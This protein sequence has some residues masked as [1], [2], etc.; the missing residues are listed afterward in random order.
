MLR[1]LDTV[2][3]SVSSKL[4]TDMT[5]HGLLA[6]DL[7]LDTSAKYSEWDAVVPTKESMMAA[8]PL[9]WDVELQ[10]C[11]PKTAKE[12]LCEQQIKLRR[13]WEIVHAAFPE[14]L[15]DDYTYAWLLINTRSFYYTTPRTAKLPRADRMVLQPVADLFNHA[16]KGC[17]VSFDA[18]SFTIVCDR[19]YRAGEEVFISYGAHSNDF[20]LAEY[21]FI[22]GD[23]RWDEVCIDDVILPHLSD[24]QKENLEDRSFL[25]NYKIDAETACYRTIIALT[26]LCVP[27]KEWLMVVDGLEGGEEYRCE[28][29]QLLISLLREFEVTARDTMAKVES[30]TAGLESQRRMLKDRWA[31]ILEL[32]WARYFGS[33]NEE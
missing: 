10:A 18:E 19:T 13:D 21:G 7:A 17:S 20:L 5:V 30:S 25:G 8:L 32:I 27:L 6:A 33:E 29:D 23:N 14:I 15:E 3:K 31:Q 4:P 2:P 16:D 9:T 24:A 22:L 12:L 28:V 11:L 26:I 1:T